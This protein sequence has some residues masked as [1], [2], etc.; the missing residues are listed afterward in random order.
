MQSHDSPRFSG[1]E[2]RSKTLTEISPCSGP[3]LPEEVEEALDPLPDF[4]YTALR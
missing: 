2:G 3:I 1:L 4:C